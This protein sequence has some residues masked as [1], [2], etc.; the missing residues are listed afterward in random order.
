MAIDASTATSWQTDWYSSPEFGNLK[1]GT[2]LLIDMG[3]AVRI[4]SVHLL[5]GN[6]HGAD[7]LL[8]TEKT[9][10]LATDR[11]QASASNAGGALRLDLTRPKRA[12][13]LL[14]WFTSLPPDPAGTFQVNVYNVSAWGTP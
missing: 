4:T 11:G 14:I 5:L 13:Y 7:L 1:P 8:R 10:T 12:R 3:H 9:P 6:T 2:G